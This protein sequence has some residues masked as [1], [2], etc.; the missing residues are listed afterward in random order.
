M[1]AANASQESVETNMSGVRMLT[2][3]FTPS[4]PHDD[5]DQFLEKIPVNDIWKVYSLGLLYI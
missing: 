2:E 3:E 4:L 5:V 1:A